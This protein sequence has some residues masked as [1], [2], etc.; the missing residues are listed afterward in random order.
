MS[1]VSW[2]FLEVVGARRAAELTSVRLAFAERLA[3]NKKTKVAERE[4]RRREE[5]G[6]VKPK[7]E[8]SSSPGPSGAPRRGR[9]RGGDV[10]RRGARGEFLRFFLRCRLC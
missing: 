4:A 3:R 5:R 8:A 1:R 2:V 6:D 10:D 9:G 7:I